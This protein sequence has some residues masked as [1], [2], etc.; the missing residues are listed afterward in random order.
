MTVGDVAAVAAIEAGSLSPWSR[1]QVA[2]ELQ[3]KTGFSL[4]ATGSGGEIE[5]WCCG[6]QAGMD[7]DLLKVTVRIERRRKGTA[8]A[9]LR[10]LCSQFAGQG[11][12]QLF[13]E[14]RS[15]NFPA[16]QLYAKL[17]WQETGRRKNY[18]KKPVDDAVILVRRFNKD[19]G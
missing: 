9:L 4:V 19:K 6:F 15:L 11:L 13:L 8:E 16:L 3:K 10:E 18:Y 1:G 7:A 2:A 17:G 12:E 14:V 5:A